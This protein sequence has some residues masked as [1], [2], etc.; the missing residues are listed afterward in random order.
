MSKTFYVYIV[1]CKDRSF[2]TGYTNNL[3]R[4]I[5]QHNDGVGG[6]YTR[7]R[8]PVELLYFE[9]FSTQKEA[10]RREREVKKLSRKQKMLLIK[11]QET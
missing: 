6:R 3:E 7:S 11:N 5:Q 2:Y 9:T 4:R 8:R 10:M 1:K